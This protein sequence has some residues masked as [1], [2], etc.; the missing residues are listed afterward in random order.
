MK[1]IL[2]PTDFSENAYNAIRYAV[3]LFKNIECTFHL[4]NTYRPPAYHSEFKEYSPPHID[5]KDTYHTDSMTNLKKLQERIIANG[6]PNHK[7]IIHSE[8]NTLVDEVLKTVKNESIDMVI[9]GT[10]GATGAKEILFG[11]STVHL[12]K[13]AKCPVIA[14]PAHF[15]YE[16][17]KRILFPTDFE[18]NYRKE[19]FEQL[20]DIIDLNE[21]KVNI[22]HVRNGY[23]LSEEKLVNKSKLE[24]MMRS[25]T[26]F[27]EVP[28]MEIIKAINDFIS[29]ERTNFLVM[30]RNKH[31]FI[32][33]LFIEPV[34]KK[35]GFHISIPFMVLPPNA[36]NWTHNRDIHESTCRALINTYILD[37]LIVWSENIIK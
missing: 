25:Q 32:E 17:P 18:I 34:I 7:F 28:D 30:I 2:L 33:H 5:L 24:H 8:L 31:T 6:N 20:L 4:M 37:L 22:L 16:A 21:S 11:T 29:M 36:N 1:R 12:I 27:N 3:Q 13:K 10:K 9:M 19:Q 15:I 23:E 35:I 26:K 14:I